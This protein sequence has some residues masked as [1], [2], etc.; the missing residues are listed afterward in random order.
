MP[1]LKDTEEHQLF[2]ESP[3]NRTL[4]VKLPKE[5][6]ASLAP[7]AGPRT[8]AENWR[9]KTETAKEWMWG[10]KKNR[11]GAESEK[12]QNQKEWLH[13][14]LY[15]HYVHMSL[16]SFCSH[17]KGKLRLRES[18]LDYFP[19]VAQLVHSR[20]GTWTKFFQHKA[21]DWRCTSWPWRTSLIPLLPWEVSGLSTP[22]AKDG[23]PLQG[24]LRAGPSTVPGSWVWLCIV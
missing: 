20:A 23:Q 18:N 1:N 22:S 3:R 15:I 13:Q 8:Q 2:T 12:L 5:L 9:E 19:R 11:K 7:W 21:Y 16:A 24:A 4:M 14:V 17:F 10:Q 6:R